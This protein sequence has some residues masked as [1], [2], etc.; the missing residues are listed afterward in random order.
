MPAPDQSK[1]DTGKLMAY[2]PADAK[3]Y[4]ADIVEQIAVQDDTRYVVH[5]NTVLI[6]ADSPEDAYAN[7]VELSNTSVP[8]KNSAFSPAESHPKAPTTFLKTCL[9]NCTNSSRN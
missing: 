7:A 4:L 2:I 5:T 6:R 1:L 9:R 3:W 8:K